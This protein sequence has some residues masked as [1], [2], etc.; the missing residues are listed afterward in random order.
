MGRIAICAGT[1]ILS[2][3]GALAQGD[4]VLGEQNFVE[5]C[6]MCHSIGGQEPKNGPDLTDII[7]R[8]AASLDGFA[9]SDAML[10]AGQAGV[11]WDVET[12]AKFIAKPRSVV[13][14]SSMAFTG[15]RDPADVANV[16][17][18]LATFS[19]APAQ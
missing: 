3:G 2:A 13:N 9:Y 18:Y 12:L 19:T 10:E 17:A 15:Y 1:L 5:R 6:A 8:P 14:G 16:I 7:D 4:A 11:V